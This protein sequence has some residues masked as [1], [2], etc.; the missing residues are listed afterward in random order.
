MGNLPKPRVTPSRAF[1]HTGVDLAGP[2]LV[3]DGKTRNRTYLK[4]YICLFVCFSTKAVHLELVGDLTKESLLNALKRFFSRRG[5][6]SDI[7]SDNGTNLV[8]ASNE[9]KRMHVNLCKLLENTSIQSYLL[10]K[11]VNWHFIPPRSPHMGGIWESAI[12]SAKVHL[13]KT[14][15]NIKL[16]YEQFYT[17]VTQVEAI[18]NSRPLTPLSNDPSDLNPLTPGHFFIGAS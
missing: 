2:F 15:G 12:K 7:Y 17:V 3:K 18:M 9:L 13:L 6:S 5:Y 14:L 8:G 1:S 10:E 11:Q 16:D 4:S